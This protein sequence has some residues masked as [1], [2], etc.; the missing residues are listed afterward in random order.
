MRYTLICT[1]II[2]GIGTSSLFCNVAEAKPDK[3]W[4]IGF[5][6]VGRLEEDSCFGGGV[7]LRYY[8]LSPVY[9]HIAGHLLTEGD[10]FQNSPMAGVSYAI[11]EYPDVSRLYLSL[12]A[13]RRYKEQ[14]SEWQEPERDTLSWW[15]SQTTYYG[16]WAVFGAEVTL[17]NSRFGIST[18]L[19]PG[20]VKWNSTEEGYNSYQGQ[21]SHKY[22]DTSLAFVFNVGIHL[23][24]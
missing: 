6:G 3:H 4:S 23:Y 22:E 19:G 20:A 10:K 17:P 5:Q 1:A 2:L 21:Y 16:A 8:G 9:F 18:E 14:F 7:S 15:R 11:L 12:Q 13:G 24:F